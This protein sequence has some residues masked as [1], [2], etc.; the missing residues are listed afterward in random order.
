MPWL[1]SKKTLGLMAFERKSSQELMK[2]MFGVIPVLSIVDANRI[3]VLGM[4]LS[5]DFHR[6]IF[7]HKI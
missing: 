1:F 2:N 3:V 4:V 7:S 6:N 5:I